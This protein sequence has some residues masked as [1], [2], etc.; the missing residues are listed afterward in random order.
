[1]SA[2]SRTTNLGTNHS[3]ATVLN[4][5][6]VFPRERDEKTG[7]PRSRVE[8]RLRGKQGQVAAR[9]KVNA[10]LFIVEQCP[11]ERPFRSLRPQDAESFRAELL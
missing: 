4:F 5:G 2:A 11:A 8:F 3:V 7:P 6:D 10:G 9:T 1:M